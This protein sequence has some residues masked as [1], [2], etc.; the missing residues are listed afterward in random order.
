MW[1]PASEEHESF[2]TKAY[3]NTR[4]LGSR[5]GLVLVFVLAVIAIS[6]FL[7]GVTHKYEAVRVVGCILM[8]IFL[9]AAMVWTIFRPD[10]GTSIGMTKIQQN[11]S[12]VTIFFVYIGIGLVLTGFIF[13]TKRS[14]NK[15]YY[16]MIG[17]GA[18]V[19]LGGTVVTFIA[20][21]AAVRKAKR[22]EEYYYSI[23]ATEGD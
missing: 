6:T 14:D 13:Q 2:N 10:F 7:Y 22:K 19:F 21:V 4:V 8:F 16:L 5:V 3:R 15:G 17:G 11:I 18:L 12:R 23:L 20:I 1:K 9:L